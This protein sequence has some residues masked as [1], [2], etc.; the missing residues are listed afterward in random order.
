[1][2]VVGASR[3][4]GASVAEAFARED[5]KLTLVARSPQGLADVAL[6]CARK[7]ARVA[8]L[9]LDI[10]SYDEVNEKL[11]HAA[12]GHCELVVFAA[13]ISQ[14]V[15]ERAD[16]IRASRQIV[17]TNLM[18]AM[19]VVDVLMRRRQELR[20]RHLCLVTSL[21][22]CRGIYGAF[23]YCASKA[24]L[25]RFA[26]GLRPMLREFG[27][28]ISVIRPG[29][30]D[31][32]MYRNSGFSTRWAISPERFAERVKPRILAGER[33]INVPV[34]MNWAFRTIN[35]VLPRRL[36]DVLITRAVRQG[37]SAAKNA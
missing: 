13:G 12:I 21:S 19:N 5:L 8:Q 29:V 7:G 16:D 32:D 11:T 28:R 14:G 23:A 35:R 36:T 24:G 17:E 6:R 31:T 33:E 26:E 2:L 18:G 20:M 9:P 4:I 10:R 15:Y 25:E 27:I 30:V 22:E 3:G 34:M 1:L 37:R